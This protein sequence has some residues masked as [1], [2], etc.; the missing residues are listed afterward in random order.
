M[1]TDRDT[2]E[3]SID[4]NDPHAAT[5]MLWNLLAE[6]VPVHDAARALFGLSTDVVRKLAGALMATAP[7]TNAL[8]AAMPELL[9]NLSITTIQTAERSQGE[10]RGPILWSET[11]AARSATAGATDVFV[12][13]TAERAYDTSENRVLVAALDAVKKAAADADPVARQAYDD[14]V[15]L[16]A[17]VN[18]DEA[19]RYLEHRTLRGVSRKRLA[20]RDRAKASGGR[21]S[22]QCRPAIAVLERAKNPIEVR[23]LL[24]FSDARTVW[25]HWVIVTLAAQLRERGAP[26]G[27]FRITPRGELR[28]GRLTYRHPDVAAEIGSE[29]HGIVFERLLIDVPDPVGNR[30]PR[31][32]SEALTARAAGRVPVLVTGPADVARAADLAFA[33]LS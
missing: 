26:L 10:V 27:A 12:C 23:H 13:L 1:A 5:R 20:H 21:R 33:N 17:R 22:Q 9:R 8:L 30:D 31:S 15:L 2:D 19:R 16:Q 7:E 28:A 29:P 32:A 18:G 24:A 14:E 11:M 6:P 4:R 25:Q 3:R